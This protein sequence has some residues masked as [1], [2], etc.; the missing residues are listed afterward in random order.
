MNIEIWAERRLVTSEFGLRLL[1]D[2]GGVRPETVLIQFAYTRS[3]V[4]LK[5]ECAFAVRAGSFRV[6]SLL[7]RSPRTADRPSVAFGPP[8]SCRVRISRP[9]DTSTGCSI[10]GLRCSHGQYSGRFFR[11][12]IELQSFF[13]VEKS[14]N[15]I[16]DS[17]SECA[18]LGF[19]EVRSSLC[20]GSVENL[21]R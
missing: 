7:F 11:L 4:R 6:E 19:D 16:S 15:Y 21:S 14:Y 3:A 18:M 2:V 12:Y 8:F 9:T 1:L 13:A 5:K 17:H 10:T 20:S